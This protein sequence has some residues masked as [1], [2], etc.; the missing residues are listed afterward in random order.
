MKKILYVATV[1]GFLPQ[2]QRNDVKIMQEKGYEVHY[3]A[4]FNVPIYSFDEE[5]LEKQ[6][7]VLHHINI[8]KSIFKVFKNVK[9]IKEVKSV[10]D[11]EVIDIVHCNNPMGGVAGRVAGRFSK[12][13]PY[14][15][16]TAHGFHFYKGAKVINWLCFYPVERFLARWTDAIICINKEDRKRAA[17]FRLKKNGFVDQIH[18]VGVD[19]NRFSARKSLRDDVRE[20]LGVPKDAFHIVTAAE[21][22]DNKNQSTIINAISKCSN[23]NIYYSICGKGPNHD[24]LLKLIEEKNLKDRVRLLGYRN[25]MER[26]LQSADVF[27]FPS[28]REGLGIAAVEALSCGVPLLAADNRGTREY[29]VNYRN[30]LVYKP[31]DV[32]GFALGIRH[33]VADTDYLERLADCSRESVSLFNINETDLKMRE[34]YD[35]VCNE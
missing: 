21:L 26:I 24:R 8:E 16:Y 32:N 15:I 28:V 10:I 7:I 18:G 3:A 30:A 14:V 31:Y 25:D 12:N 23:I 6:G 19:M 1:G 27:A 9:A 35:R 20:E 4:N 5:E 2:F 11:E 29:A 33:L 22:N 34:I 13:R 17:T